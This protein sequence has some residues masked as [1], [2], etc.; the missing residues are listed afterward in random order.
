MTQTWE[1]VAKNNKEKIEILHQV[2]DLLNYSKDPLGVTAWW[3][4]ANH[5]FGYYDEEDYLSPLMVLAFKV[6]YDMSKEF[7]L[8][9]VQKDIE[10]MS[11]GM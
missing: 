3:S 5:W 6:P 7:F 2:N 9:C 8:I 10:D 1:E 4:E 11:R